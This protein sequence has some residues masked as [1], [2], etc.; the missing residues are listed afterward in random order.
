MFVIKILLAWSFVMMLVIAC[1]M[2]MCLRTKE[3]QKTVK[4]EVHVLH[5]TVAT[6]AMCTYKRKYLQPRSAVLA[7]DL[8]GAWTSGM[9]RP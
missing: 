5:R 4:V 9:E 2:M 7:E 6:Q 1:M 3:S 8:Q